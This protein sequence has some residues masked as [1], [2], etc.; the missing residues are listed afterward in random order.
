VGKSGR[1]GCTALARNVAAPARNLQNSKDKHADQ[2][3]AL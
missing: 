1:G 2:K 3:G